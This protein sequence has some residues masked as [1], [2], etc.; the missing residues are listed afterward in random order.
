M[1]K[2]VTFYCK[3]L[4]KFLVLGFLFIVEIQ[5]LMSQI[6]RKKVH[7]YPYQASLF[8]KISSKLKSIVIVQSYDLKEPFSNSVMIALTKVNLF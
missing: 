5:K 3:I 7:F 8:T 2:T 6:I 4:K 1:E